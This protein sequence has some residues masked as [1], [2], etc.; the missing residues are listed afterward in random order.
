MS[1][2]AF[3]L[4]N[5]T[6]N[7]TGFYADVQSFRLAVFIAALAFLCV[8]GMHGP[9]FAQKSGGGQNV[10]KVEVAEIKTEILANFIDVQGRIVAGASESVNATTNAITEIQQWQIGDTLVPGDI[11]AV[12]IA[13]KLK[14]SLVQLRARLNEAKVKLVDNEAEI[15][16]EAEL[17]EII[18]AQS[19][20]L[21][22]KA[23][24]ARDLVANNAL[25][26]DAAETSLNASL[27][28]KLQVLGRESSIVRKKAQRQITM[29][30]VKQL[31]AELKQL[32]KD[33]E[34][35]KLR[36]QTAGQITFLADYSRGYAREGDV[37]A[38]I[39]D[40]NQFEI[41][42]EIPV[43]YVEF[44]QNATIISGRGLDGTAVSMALRVALPVQ[45]LRT[46]TRTARFTIN[47]VNGKIPSA[48]Q[49]DNALVV[50][51]IPVSSPM[52]QVIVPKDAVL[53]INGGHLVY[54]A[55]DG[56][57]KRQLIQL[58]AAV[59]NGFIVKNGLLAGQ[60][61]IVRGNEQ[62]SDGK[63]INIGSQ[64]AGGTK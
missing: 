21:A 12:Q 15:K 40:L 57:A 31:N 19:A 41:E 9:A 29:G 24:R 13:D 32:T 23:V 60:T 14:L 28:A 55:Q 6:D 59:K 38:R 37:I 51:Q 36:A 39:I 53:P 64:K 7:K 47:G 1:F 27:N 35:T 46:A 4:P 16:A 62:L 18:K 63:E 33:I 22:G 11:I 44:T 3:P 25:S 58:G 54:L 43:K 61:V 2:S 17:L 20:L 26:I 52:P 56:R 30:I 49:A 34:A 48:L 50:L 42:A 10:A 8:G 45:N 5:R